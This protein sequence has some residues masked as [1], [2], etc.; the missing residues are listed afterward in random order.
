MISQQELDERIR[1]ANDMFITGDEIPNAPP[2]PNAKP[3]EAVEI[4][5]GEPVDIYRLNMNARYDESLKTRPKGSSRL[6]KAVTKCI[7]D[8]DDGSEGLARAKRRAEDD[9]DMLLSKGEKGRAKM[10]RQQY[11]EENFLPAVEAVVNYTSPDE[12]LNCKEALSALDEMALGDGAMKGYTASY[13]RQAYKDQI[14]QKRGESDPAVVDAVRRILML[15]DDDQYRTAVGLAK[16]LKKNIDEG[17]NIAS[18]EDYAII[19]RMVAY[20]N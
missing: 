6:V 17:E 7:I 15:V 13:V 14:G 5:T 8:G 19:G 9:S 12:L 1:K 18:D 2:D 16:K 10:V 11:M 3:E 20:A 4:G